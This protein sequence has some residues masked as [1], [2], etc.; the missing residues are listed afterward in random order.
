MLKGAILTAKTA[1]VDFS[2]VA[3]SGSKLTRRC[4]QVPLFARAF[5][6]FL[7]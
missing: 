7:M 4:S 1:D 5:E 2:G 6:I 3:I